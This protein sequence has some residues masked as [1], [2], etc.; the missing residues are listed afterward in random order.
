V[1]GAEGDGGEVVEGVFVVAGGD[2]AAPLLEAPE[3]A[4]DGVAFFE[5]VGVEVWQPST[6]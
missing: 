1:G 6:V 2:R 4:F 3:A 5:Q